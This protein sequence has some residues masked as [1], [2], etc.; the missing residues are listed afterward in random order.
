MSMPRMPQPF[1]YGFIV[2]DLSSP[3]RGIEFGFG[4]VVG[5]RDCPG[6]TEVA[7]G[8]DAAVAGRGPGGR[9]CSRY[10]VRSDK[11]CSVVPSP[12]Q[13]QWVRLGYAII[14]NGRLAATRALI[15]RSV[16]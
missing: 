6:R 2:R 7:F 14:V 15:S 4:D 1:H 16:A 8:G 5:H 12:S 13:M 11:R 9:F 3:R 10:R